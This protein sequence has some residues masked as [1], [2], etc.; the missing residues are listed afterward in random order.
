MKVFPAGVLGGLPFIRALHGPFPEM[1]FMPSGGV[2]QA[3]AAEY[4]AERAI[5]AVSGSWMVPSEAIR[6]GDFET[7]TTSARATMAALDA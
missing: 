2:D 1:R 5:F 6:D 4:L 7:I 3:K